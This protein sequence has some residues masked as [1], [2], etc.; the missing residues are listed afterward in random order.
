MELKPFDFSKNINKIELIQRLCFFYNEANKNL[1]LMKYDK[2][3]SFFNFKR[4]YHLLKEEY[5]EYKKERNKNYILNNGVYS[6]YVSNI[7]D[8][9][10]K[11]LNTNSYEDLA[12]NL[13]NICDYM[14][15]GFSDIFC[16]GDEYKINR[17]SLESYLYKECIIILNDYSIYVGK[18]NIKLIDGEN[19]ELE[20]I[21]LLFF[22]KWIQIPINS[23]NKIKLF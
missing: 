22:D 9:Y 15:Y 5:N 1:E 6:Q 21:S 8:A 19:R 10:V 17:D 12:S 20:S 2:R 7:T 14:W 23:I 18:T 13:Y 4:L 11:C 3:K 16:L